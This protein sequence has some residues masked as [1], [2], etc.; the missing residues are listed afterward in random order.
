M[1]PA[2][3]NTV[4]SK[5]P[6]GRQSQAF[7]RPVLVAGVNQRLILCANSAGSSTFLYEVMH[8]AALKR[9]SGITVRFS[10]ENKIMSEQYT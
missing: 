4:R 8:R 7:A 2:D 1:S 5:S 6:L 10:T 3:V 9:K